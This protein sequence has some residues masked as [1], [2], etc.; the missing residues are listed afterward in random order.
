MSMLVERETSAGSEGARR[1]TGDPAGRDAAGVPDPE[2]SEQAKRRRF[3]AEYKLRIVREADAC[4]GDGDVAALLRRE[5]LYSSHLSSWRRQ[6]DEVAQEGLASRKRGRKAKAEDPRV[7]ELERENARLQ[8]RLAR[9]ETML[10][11]P[12]LDPKKNLRTTGD[13]P[14]STRQRR[15]RLI[16]AA[17]ELAGQIGQTTEACEALGV[18]RST[19]YRRRQPA[20]P[21]PKRRPRPHR[22]LDETEREEVLGALHCER[23]VDK[24]PAQVWATLLDEGT[25]LC[26]IRTMYRILEEHGEVRERRNQR[27]HPNYTKPELL[28]EAPNQVWSWDIT[29][30][31]GPVKWTYYYLYVILDIFSRYV[32]GWML[33]HRESAAL[34]QR[35]IA[36]SCRKQD[37][38]RDQLTLHADRGSSMRSKPVGLLLLTSELP[39]PTPGLTSRTTIPTPSLSSRR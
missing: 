15:D 36:E 4:K 21:Q 12:H 28:A 5:G 10:E 11:S 14:E 17:E 13:P 23:F 31:R 38:E 22:A 3:T 1:A 20:G 35:L 19:L 16:V 26:S 25:Y 34:A 9:V 7:K 6:R 37:I 24:A 39:R 8:R 30:L 2:V 18:A 29:K 33:A 32:V 27:R